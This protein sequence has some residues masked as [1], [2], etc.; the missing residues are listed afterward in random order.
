MAA[1]VKT[2]L[3]IAVSWGELLNVLRDI[4]F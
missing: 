2:L 3:L 1:V 4:V